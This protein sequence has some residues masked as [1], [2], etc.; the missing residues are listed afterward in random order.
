MLSHR[1]NRRLS[2]VSGGIS[3]ITL[4]ELLVVISIFVAI[5]GVILG[6]MIDTRK[7]VISG[8][9][10]L[11]MEN[12]ARLV[13]DS[14]SQ[15]ISKS[16]RPSA[17]DGGTTNTEVIFRPDQCSLI[18]TRGFEGKDLQIWT[19][20]NQ[21]ATDEK[22][23]QVLCYPKSLDKGEMPKTWNQVAG[24]TDRFE[25]SVSFRYATQPTAGAV[26]V[27]KNELTDG[28]YP[29]LVEARISVTDK[30]SGKEAGQP[31]SF[32]LVICE[33]VL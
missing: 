9:N 12:Q 25:T 5:F 28:E 10:T 26:D 29:R 11:T 24:I 20:K 22:K 17:L 31:E 14:I 4:V 32:V 16:V 1:K 7:A 6:I 33:P 30:D 2:E 21:K 3:G 18:S 15:V 19:I 8:Q 23:A 13:A 27:F